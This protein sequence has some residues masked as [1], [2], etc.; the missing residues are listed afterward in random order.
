MDQQKTATFLR[1]IRNTAG[2][3]H[4]GSV[5]SSRMQSAWPHLV[6]ALSSSLG[7]VRP[8][9]S[10][11]RTTSTCPWIHASTRPPMLGVARPSLS[12]SCT[13]A[14]RPQLHAVSSTHA[15]GC[16]PSARRRPTVSVSPFAHAV[17]IDTKLPC[18][19]I[20]SW[21]D[22]K[23]SRFRCSFQTIED[24]VVSDNGAASIVWVIE[25]DGAETETHRRV[26]TS[27]K[28][29]STRDA[30][31]NGKQT[32]VPRTHGCHA[33]DLQMGCVYVAFGHTLPTKG[34]CNTQTDTWVR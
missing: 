22:V 9:A 7:S 16:T 15:T 27:A 25:T 29:L 34:A 23:S 2:G 18:M 32:T 31:G 13:T 20:V 14:A 10:S 28:P 12:S 3:L 1:D 4:R 6:A 26:L 8:S 19:V 24:H 33:Q 11:S 17:N 30:F 21:L 5:M